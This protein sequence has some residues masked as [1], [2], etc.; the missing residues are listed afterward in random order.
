[1]D[2]AVEA[3]AVAAAV[4]AEW[5]AAANTG[6]KYSLN[7]SAQALNLFN[8]IDKGTPAAPWEHL[9]STNPPAWPP[10]CSPPARRRRGKR[11]SF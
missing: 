7:F 4:L 6:R 2:R 11:L 9:T 10:E 1:L 8:D 5:A 3:A